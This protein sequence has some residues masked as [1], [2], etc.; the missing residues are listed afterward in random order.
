M[1]H[2]ADKYVTISKFICPMDED[3]AC[4]AQVYNAY[5][6]KETFVEGLQS[7]VG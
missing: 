6:L 7:A 1:L 2:P 3:T 5:I 4:C